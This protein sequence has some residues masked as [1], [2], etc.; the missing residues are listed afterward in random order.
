MTENSGNPQDGSDNS[1]KRLVKILVIIFIGVPI[2]I[3]LMTLFNILNVQFFEDDEKEVASE[4]AVTQ[5]DELAE[6]DTLWT[7]Y[8]APVLLKSIRIKVRGQDWKFELVFSPSDSTTEQDSLVQVDS[9]KLQS[10]EI[11]RT[12][13]TFSWQASEEGIPELIMEWK[14]P[15]GDIPT[16]LYLRSEQQIADDSTAM[17]PR[18]APLDKIPVRYNADES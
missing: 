13:T 14:L 12:D 18:E 7:D 6:G 17:V 1:S 5:V 10:D 16:T 2:L 8:A 9:L 3:E 4:E 15:P 11:L